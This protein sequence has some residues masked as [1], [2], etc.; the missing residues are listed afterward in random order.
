MT[1]DS[2]TVSRSDN[3]LVIASF[4]GIGDFFLALPMLGSLRTAFG[5][6]F[7]LLVRRESRFLPFLSTMDLF[8]RIFVYDKTGRDRSIL[9]QIQLVR[10]L[11][12]CGFDTG[13]TLHPGKRYVLLLWLSGIRNRI[14]GFE[15]RWLKGFLTHPLPDPGY[16]PDFCHRF[17]IDNVHGTEYFLH[18]LA[19]AGVEP[20]RTDPVITIPGYIENRARE[21]AERFSGRLVGVNAGS[22]GEGKNW[23]LSKFISLCEAII[24]QH[25]DA[26][27]VFFGSAEESSRLKPL[28]D[29]FP[30]STWAMGRDFPLLLNTALIK[31]CRVLLT[32]DTGMVHVASF[33]N[34]PVVSIGGGRGGEPFKAWSRISD[35]VLHKVSCTTPCHICNDFRCVKEIT[36]DEVLAA[37]QN[38]WNKT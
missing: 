27:F 5:R 16:D 14:G 28:R 7:S 19:R 36:V 32:N 3:T 30:G 13:F 23:P 20:R 12:S 2:L 37:F 9:R 15:S 17:Y 18:F 31:K 33:L 6:R 4:T 22:S 34:V 24:A 1:K 8:D 11:R 29:R 10:K 21:L 35:N 25:P 26:S 38:I